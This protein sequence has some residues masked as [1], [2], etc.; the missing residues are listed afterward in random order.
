MGV[1]GQ[2]HVVEEEQNMNM[3]LWWNGR[4]TDTGLWSDLES[5]PDLCGE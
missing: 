2:G 4:P 3:E 5:N 1:G